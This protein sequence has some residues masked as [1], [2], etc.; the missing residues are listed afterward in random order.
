M[1]RTGPMAVSQGRRDRRGG[2]QGRRPGTRCSNGNARARPASCARINPGASIG[3]MPANVSV[4]RP[5]DRH[6]WVC[7]RRRSGEPIGAGDVGPDGESC[8]RLA[9]RTTPPYDRQQAERRY[10]FGDPLR[11]PGADMLRELPDRELEHDMRQPNTDDAAHDLGGDVGRH[12]MPAQAL[13]R[14]GG[15][16]HRGV[17]VGARL[18]SESKD[19]RHQR[20]AGGDRVREQGKPNISG[21]QPLG[22]DARPD[23]RDQQKRRRNE[24]DE[25]LANREGG[26]AKP[27]LPPS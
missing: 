22:H 5:S 7:E 3:R 11:E 8:H 18:W 17:H 1:G 9:V 26:S 23:H 20:G 24:L 6:R 21:A 25:C 4:K 16:C 13:R 15:K 14:R 10:D 12:R 19:Q 2:D 27:A